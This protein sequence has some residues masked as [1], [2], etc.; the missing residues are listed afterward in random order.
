MAIVFEWRQDILNGRLNWH[1]YPPEEYNGPEG[2]RFA[3][4]A[5]IKEF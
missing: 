1:L 5:A 2:W 3:W 4:L